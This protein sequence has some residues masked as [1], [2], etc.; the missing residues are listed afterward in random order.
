METTLCPLCQ[1][2]NCR[3]IHE[4][5]TAHLIASWQR[6]FGIDVSIDLAPTK[7]VDL[8]QC[9]ECL[10]KFF[11][12]ELSGGEGLYRAL[13][14]RPEYYSPMKWDYVITLNDIKKD[15]RVLEVG[16]GKGEFIDYAMRNGISR[17]QG[18]DLNLDAVAKAKQLKLPVAP[19]SL[20]DLAA[21]PMRFD[22]VCAMQVLEHVPNPREFLTQCLELL[23]PSGKLLVCVPNDDAFVGRVIDQPL[24]SPPHH[25]TRWTARTFLSMPRFL[26]VRVL[27][28][29]YEPLARNDI[30]SFVYSRTLRWNRARVRGPF[31]TMR[32]RKS[33]AHLLAATPAY[34]LLRGHTLY[35]ALEKRER[36]QD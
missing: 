12:S 11:P 36:N 1:S 13:Q 14:Q 32:L 27:S 34:Q 19:T 30:P 31:T 8:Y 9:R 28:I 17:I 4:I 2:D 21:E 3:K 5:R 16:C 35:A 18:I 20:R 26:P 22:V 10:V 29:A 24:N 25:I 6:R 33:L 15:D 23:K 7:S